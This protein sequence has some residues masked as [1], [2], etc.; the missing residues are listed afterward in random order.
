MPACPAAPSAGRRRDEPFVFDNEKWA[1]PVE[2]AAYRI[3]RS[4]VTQVEF[5]AFVE[6]GAYARRELWS[7]A[8]WA[9]RVAAGADGPLH[10]RR[11][12][13]RWER[14][15][16]DR[17][18]AL[19]PH[20][21][22]IHVSWYE[23]DAYCRWA[24]RRLPTEIE[25]EAA[26]ALEPNAGG[27]GFNG[28][29]RRFPW[30]DEATI[31]HASEHRWEGTGLPRCRRAARGRQ[32]LR[33]PADDRQRLGVDVQR[34]SPLPGFAPDMYSDYSEPWF[35]SHKVLRGGCWVTRSRLLR[36]TWRNFY[37]PDRR[38]VWAGF[39]TCAP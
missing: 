4:A 26:A 33:L 1:H 31:A 14:R 6:S 8:G 34:L 38:D 30:G 28:R 19:E 32:R 7:E 18:V 5:A 25:W 9:W 27:T 16:F 20:R 13:D 10:W 23:A 37:T 39:R 3:A 21:P 36:N 22:V 15:D 11:A 35:G 12:G 24:G 17:W 29:K 2:V